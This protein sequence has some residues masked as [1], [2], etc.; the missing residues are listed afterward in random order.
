MLST[1]A[2]ATLAS[3]GCLFKGIYATHALKEAWQ[4]VPAMLEHVGRAHAAASG[5]NAARSAGSREQATV[6]Y[7]EAAH[8][9]RRGCG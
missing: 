8:S 9:E 7:G 5:G 6:I 2:D 1:E 4:H 3:V